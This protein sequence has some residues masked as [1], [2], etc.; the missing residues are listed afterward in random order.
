MDPKGVWK[1]LQWVALAGAAACHGHGSARYEL[2]QFHFHAPSE[3]TIDGQHA[4]Q[5]S[6]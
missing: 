2:A 6:P 5:P 1:T 3:H 4:A